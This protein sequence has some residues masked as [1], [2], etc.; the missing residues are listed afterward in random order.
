MMPY[1]FSLFVRHGRA[2]TDVRLE[3]AWV[4]GNV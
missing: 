2:L 3:Y 4:V 1:S